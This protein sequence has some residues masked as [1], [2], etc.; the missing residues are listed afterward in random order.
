M[1]AAEAEGATPGRRCPSTEPHLAVV[2]EVVLEFGWRRWQRLLF[3]GRHLREVRRSNGN[4][5]TLPIPYLSS[6]FSRSTSFTFR[7]VFVIHTVL[8]KHVATAR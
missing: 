1:E 7:V 4:K 6:D 5:S 3:V 8:S 2:Y